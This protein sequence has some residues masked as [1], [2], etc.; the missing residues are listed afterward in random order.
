MYANALVLTKAIGKTDSEL[1]KFNSEEQHW[2]EGLNVITTQ[3]IPGRR[4]RYRTTK[5]TKVCRKQ[6]TG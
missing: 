5:Q 1:T 2:Q 6:G 3:V 4:S